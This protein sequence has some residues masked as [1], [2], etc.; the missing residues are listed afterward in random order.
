MYPAGAPPP[1]PEA[2]LNFCAG[3]DPAKARLA[4]DRGMFMHCPQINL[5]LTCRYSDDAGKGYIWIL[6]SI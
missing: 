6:Q 4:P 2:L 5:D 3:F 1:R